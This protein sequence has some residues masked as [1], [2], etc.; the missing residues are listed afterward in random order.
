LSISYEHK[1]AKEAVPSKLTH[2]VTS[3]YHRT[4]QWNTL[5]LS[6]EMFLH[7]TRTFQQKG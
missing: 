7:T 5:T 6:N 1:Q 3:H 2:I 4:Q